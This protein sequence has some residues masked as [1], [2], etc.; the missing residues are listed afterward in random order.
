MTAS[1]SEALPDTDSIDPY[2][3][4]VRLDPRGLTLIEVNAR[5]MAPDTYERLVANLRSDGACTQSVLVY[6]D[7]DRDGAQVVL[8][9]NHRVRA[10]IEAGLW[11]IPAELITGVRLTRQRQIAMQLSHNAIRGEDD[12]A[13]LRQLYSELGADE[14][15]DYSGL[16]VE[17]INDL[18]DADTDVEA[19]PT[20]SPT[21]HTIQLVFLPAELDRATELLHEARR[22]AKTDELWIAALEQHEQVFDALQTAHAA[23]G[24]G[25]MATALALIL[26]VFDAHLNEVRAVWYDHETQTPRRADWAPIATVFGSRTMPSEAAAITLQAVSAAIARG[27]VTADNPWRWLELVAADYLAGS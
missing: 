4:S 10:C 14:L 1:T 16:D 27:D 6:E 18:A 19:L 24:A 25:N 15:R 23:L 20:A 12:M 3:H 26:A 9:G 22:T 11:D 5:R 21:V 8:S 13:T 7:P 2:V 17:P